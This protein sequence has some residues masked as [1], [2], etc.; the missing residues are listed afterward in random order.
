MFRGSGVVLV[1]CLLVIILAAVLFFVSYFGVLKLDGLDKLL[2][3]ECGFDSFGDARSRFEVRYYLIG[4]LF[5]IFDLEIAF[6]FPFVGVLHYLGF[7]GFFVVFIF[8]FFLVA[9][10]IYELGCG[11]LD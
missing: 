5:L 11:A 2:S 7:F 6:L 8:F 3:Y 4:I 9:G 1:Y 10:L